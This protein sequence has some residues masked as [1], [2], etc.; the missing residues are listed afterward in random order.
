MDQPAKT[1]K[2]GDHG[3]PGG[4]NMLIHINGKVRYF[5]VREKA[6]LQTFPD[7][8]HFEGPW[9]AT[10]KQLGNAVPVRLSKIVCASLAKVLAP[11]KK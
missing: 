8:Y 11:K 6:R 7:K 1:L 2:A 4:E 9:S 10:T 3:V 5:T